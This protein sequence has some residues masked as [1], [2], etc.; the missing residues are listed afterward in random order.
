MGIKKILALIVAIIIIIAIAT[1]ITKLAKESFEK[2]NFQDLR[3]NLLLIEGKAKTYTENVSVETANLDEQKQEDNT[4]ISEVKDQKLKGTALENCDEK[5]KKAAKDAGIEDTK[6]YYYLSQEA[7]N[8][9]GIQIEVK[10][11]TYYLVKYNFEDTEVVYTKGFKY[12]GKTYYKLS[13][14][15]EVEIILN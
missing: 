15:K 10:E 14:M 1:T 8:S 7:L 11:G 5:I 13:E 6:D 12:E 2:T 9:M 4:K 3:T